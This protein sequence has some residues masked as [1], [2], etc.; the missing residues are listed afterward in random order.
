MLRTCHLFNW[1]KI[2]CDDYN[3]KIRGFLRRLQN[4]IL[5]RSCKNFMTSMKSFK[6]FLYSFSQQW[7]V[8]S[9]P[10]AFSHTNS[11]LSLQDVFRTTINLFNLIDNSVCKLWISC[12][13][14]KANLIFVEHLDK[15]LRTWEQ[16]SLAYIEWWLCFC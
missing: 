8:N 16:E 11:P 9:Y 4:S 14:A 2:G 7:S 6:Y 3:R 5:S 13:S 10:Q 1:K 12:I 15:H